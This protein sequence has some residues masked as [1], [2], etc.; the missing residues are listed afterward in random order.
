MQK[1]IMKKAEQIKEDGKHFDIA[2]VHIWI[3]Q[4]PLQKSNAQAWVGTQWWC[5][6][7]YS[8]Y[9]ASKMLVLYGRIDFAGEWWNI[10]WQTILIW[11]LWYT[12]IL[13]HAVFMESYR[14]KP[15]AK[16]SCNFDEHWA[17][18]GA[19]LNALRW[20]ICQRDHKSKSWVSPLTCRLRG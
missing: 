18:K 13:P 17:F 19:Y 8:I 9:T 12:G 7:A 5:C 11:R 14:T 3:A 1:P 2:S 16:K 10:N 4:P 20:G 6:I 15:H